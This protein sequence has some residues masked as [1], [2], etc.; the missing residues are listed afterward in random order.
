MTLTGSATKAQWQTALRSITYT[1]TSHTPNTGNRTINYVVNDGSFNSNTAA[2]TVSIT[3]VNDA[4]VNSMPGAQTTVMNTPRVFSTGN[5]NLISITDVDAAGG[6]MQVQLVSTNGATSL[7]T[8]TGLTFTVGD[9]TADAT[10]TFTGSFAAVNT[11][12][13]GLSFNPT[14][15]FTGAASLQIVTADQGNTGSG[16]TLT[17]S[18]TIA[19]TVGS[20][21]PTLKAQYMSLDVNAPADKWILPGLQL[22]NTGSS[23]VDLSTITVRYWFTKD[24]GASTFAAPA[25]NYAAIDCANVT[26]TVF[27]VSPSR[28]G[29]DEYLR[30]SFLPYTLAAGASSGGIMLG[31][32]KTDWSDFNE[33]DDYSYGT[34]TSYADS[35]KVTV[36]QNG[37]LIWGTE[38]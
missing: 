7:S 30:V 29:A 35:T 19:I 24:A 1:N 22:V 32:N 8:L 37:T 28:P 21:G 2:K 38:P 27:A 36:Y 33:V 26:R 3:A 34:G 18:D 23:D 9:G 17:D 6:T 11:A 14:T 25:C 10:M 31:I 16:G 15:S 20:I 5:A 12:L 4:P 13:A